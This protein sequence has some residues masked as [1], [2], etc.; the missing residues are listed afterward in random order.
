MYLL[1]DKS[2]DPVYG[3]LPTD[4]PHYWKAQLTYDL[5]W[6]TLIGINEQV[7]SGNPNSTTINLIGYSPTFINGRGDLGRTPVTSQLDLLL[8]HEF[9]LMGGVGST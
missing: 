7:T 6:G 3:L 5:P 9:T 2:G 8:Q 4:R 1:F